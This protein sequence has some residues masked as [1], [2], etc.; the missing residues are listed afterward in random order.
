MA[1]WRCPHCAT[2]QVEALRC[3]VCGRSA[4]S[5]ATCVNFRAS[6]VGG[7]GYCAL[8]KRREPLGGAEVRPC[9]TTATAAAGEGLFALGPPALAP[10][11]DQPA[12]AAARDGRERR[13]LIEVSGT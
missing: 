5:C 12:R 6:L 9:W 4:T 7:V 2:L 11:A 13:G 3:F 8:D 10:A 1:T